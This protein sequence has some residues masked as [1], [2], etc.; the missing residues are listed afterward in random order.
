MCLASPCLETCVKSC[1][2][3]RVTST[4]YLCNNLFPPTNLTVPRTLPPS[5]PSFLPSFTWP[6]VFVSRTLPCFAFLPSR[7]TPARPCSRQGPLPPPLRAFVPTVPTWD[8]MATRGSFKGLKSYQKPRESVVLK[9]A[10]QAEIQ[11]E[12]KRKLSNM[13]AMNEQLEAELT[14][15]K[16]KLYD[17]MKEFLYRKGTLFGCRRR[18]RDL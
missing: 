4:Y 17:S 15:T 16:P 18:E 6:P 10:E 8:N 14:A 9:Q 7:Q 13:A 1:I 5:L 3:D 11:A 12:L 2:V